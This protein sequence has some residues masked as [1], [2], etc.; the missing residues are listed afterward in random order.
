VFPGTAGRAR[1][2]QSGETSQPGRTGK[3][4]RYLRGALGQAAMTAAKTDTR[5]GAMYR[6]IARNRG[7]QKAIVAVSRVICEIAWILICDP[8]ARYAELGPHYCQPPS[9][10]RQTRAK[11]GAP[12]LPDCGPPVGSIRKGW[13]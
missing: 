3:G 6:R 4:H 12:S 5:L 10:A 9:P 8:S 2:Q 13:V 1:S 7:K 11:W